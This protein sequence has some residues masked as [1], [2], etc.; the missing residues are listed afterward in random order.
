MRGKWILKG[1]GIF[2]LIL[3]VLAAAG[4]VVMSLWNWL[5]PSI[6]GW[7]AIDFVQAVGLLVLARL[8]FGG[9]GFGWGH[10]R[11]HHRWKQRMAE[12]WMA[13][14]PEE[15]EKFKEGMRAR[16]GHPH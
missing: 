6:V 14:T 12:R 4:W 1:M 15:R 16:C 8:L 5:I 11:G 2:V 10:H 3:V 13:M 7:K 9:R